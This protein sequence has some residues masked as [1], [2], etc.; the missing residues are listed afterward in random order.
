MDEQSKLAHNLN[1]AF[2]IISGHVDFLTDYS[3]QQP[4]ISAH[5]NA[6]REAL[7]RAAKLVHDYQCKT[8]HDRHGKHKPGGH[9]LSQ[10]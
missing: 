9:G 2:A 4:A 1:N 10:P 7:W 5:V 8:A 6:I 3:Q